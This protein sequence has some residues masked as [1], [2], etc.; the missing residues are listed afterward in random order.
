MRVVVAVLGII[1]L[2]IVLYLTGTGQG[3]EACMDECKN[4]YCMRY[5]INR[6]DCPKQAEYEVCIDG[7]YE[8]HDP[9]QAA[10]RKRRGPSRPR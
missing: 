7:C 5:D 10:A 2:F 3:L 6:M 9:D 8:T 4:S 1:T